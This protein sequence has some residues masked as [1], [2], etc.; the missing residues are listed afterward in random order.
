MTKLEIAQR[1]AASHNRL[2]QIMVCGDNAI[3]MGDAL[4]ELRYLVQVIQKD[5]DEEHSENDGTTENNE[6][7]N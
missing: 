3:L 7:T 1:I 6:P 4:K 5:A 2:T